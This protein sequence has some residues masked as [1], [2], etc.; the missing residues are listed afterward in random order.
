MAKVSA[1]SGSPGCL[2]LHS[3]RSSLVTCLLTPH[4]LMGPRAPHLPGS[5]KTPERC[6]G[7]PES[8]APGRLQPV[9]RECWGAVSLLDVPGEH[10][11]V[12]TRGRL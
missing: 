8:A 2:G 12:F 9:L 3:H 1:A 4:N 11:L 10:L 5:T 7:F 6:W